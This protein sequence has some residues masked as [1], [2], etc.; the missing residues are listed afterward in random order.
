MWGL[1]V[2]KNL[3][4]K[5]V[6]VLQN[7]EEINVRPLTF[8]G[9]TNLQPTD[10]AQYIDDTMENVIRQ[11][12]YV[13]S[14]DEQENENVNSNAYHWLLKRNAYLVSTLRIDRKFNPKSVTQQ[15]LEKSET[16][17]AECKD[18]IVAQKWR[19][20]RDVLCL[21]TKHTDEMVNAA[22]RGKTIFK[23]KMVFEYNKC[24]AYNTSLR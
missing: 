15:K 24:K 19:D 21:S 1:G 14:S 22:K 18:G 4:N 7:D 8:K 16:V 6:D 12:H 10:K 13:S 9:I 11:M 17:G 5:S 20:R 23:P 2:R 3:E